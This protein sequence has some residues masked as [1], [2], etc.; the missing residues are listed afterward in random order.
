MELNY[1]RLIILDAESLAELGIGAAY[2]RLLPELRRHVAHPVELDEFDDPHLPSYSV[3]CAGREYVIYAP[4]LAAVPESSWD[5]ATFAF[6]DIVNRQLAES[7]VRLFAISSGN[8][9]CG[10]FLT[11]E[12]ALAARESLPNRRDWPYLPDADAPWFDEPR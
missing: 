5:R 2:S 7:S 4:Q 1:D 6:F 9:L 10:M 11:P 3:R 8:D 12:Q